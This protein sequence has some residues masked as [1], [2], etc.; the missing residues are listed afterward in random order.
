MNRDRVALF[1]DRAAAEPIRQRLLLA[2]IPAEIHDEL[3]MARLWFVSKRSIG[4]RVEVPVRLSETA[5]QLLLTWEAAEGALH[6]AIR[7]PECRSLRVDYPQFTQKFF[8]PNLAIGLLAALGL[9]EKD[10]YCEAC[11]YMWPKPSATPGRARVH[12][13]PNQL[14]EGVPQTELLVTVRAHTAELSARECL[15][16]GSVPVLSPVSR[17]LLPVP[18]WGKTLSKTVPLG[19]VMLLLGGGTGLAGSANPGSTADTGPPKTPESKP[20]RACSLN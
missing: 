11:H 3:G 2:G 19:G 10:Y 6:A 15:A 4:V 5:Q 7:C 18:L 20:G 12:L 16:G 1:N 9:V 8:F 14:I 17:L 13:A